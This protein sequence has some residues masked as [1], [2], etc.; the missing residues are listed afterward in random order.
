MCTA[1]LEDCD[2]DAKVP[3]G[4]GCETNLSNDAAN[5][6]GCGT[7]CYYP[8]ASGKCVNKGCVLDKCQPGY[9]D[10]SAV[11]GCE[12][13]LGTTMNCR[14][15][16]EACSNAHGSTAC[17]ATGCKPV[18]ALGWDDCDGKPENGCETSLTSIDSCGA[19]GASCSKAHGSAS[20]ATGTCQIASCT[21][22]WDDCD[23]EATTKNGCETDLHT[24]KTCGA[25][26]KACSYPN[27]AASCP[28]G[29]CV[30]G[31]CDAGFGDC[32]AT[33]GCETPL[34]T[35]T[36]CATCNNACTNPHGA[37]ACSAV[38]QSFDCKPTCD[39]GFKNCDNNPDNGCEA[40]LTTATS[41]GDCGVKCT[42]S[43][44]ACIAGACLNALVNSTTGSLL[45]TT[46]KLDFQHKLAT[47]A[48]R[49]RLVVVVVGS[50]GSS[51]SASAASS[52][53]YDGKTM[54]LAKGVWAG[55]RVTASVFYIKDSALPAPGTYTVSIGGGDYAKVA[56]VYELRGIDQTNPAEAV[57]GSAGGDCGTDGPSDTITTT[58]ANDFIVTGVATFGS[59][60]GTPKGN[61]QTP[62]EAYTNQSGSLGF[63]SGY[64]LNAGTGLRTLGWDMSSCN[65][66][67]QALVA[68]KAAP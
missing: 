9:A 7:A 49:S 42:G 35:D 41:C 13:A 11:A 25:C 58:T 44:P 26:G 20:C 43:T 50:D 45:G 12:T 67:A 60:L 23:D 1:P 32:G 22:G 15:C 51:Q 31:A 10:C 14:V 56:Q 17:T 46:G 8:N 30:Q 59:N 64:L 4:N 37:T 6:G 16:G 65:N 19:C 18:C 27:A 2:N 39:A 29:K 40:D 24:L 38:A 34:G 62:A 63:K 61:P 47:A 57:G 54:T 5:C 21:D 48:G 33:A 53:T 66:S 36:D 55:M 28:A 68:F 3:G 52:A